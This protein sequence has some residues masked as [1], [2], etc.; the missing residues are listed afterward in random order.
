[1]DHAFTNVHRGTPSVQITTNPV[2]SLVVLGGIVS[3]TLAEQL[4]LQLSTP[5]PHR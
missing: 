1:L 5:K 3:K 4:R 2:S